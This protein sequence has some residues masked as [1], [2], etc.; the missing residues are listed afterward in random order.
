MRGFH[1][2]GPA[3]RCSLAPLNLSPLNTHLGGP[4]P[5]PLV[6]PSSPSATHGTDTTDPLSGPYQYL[7]PQLSRSIPASK[8]RTLG[9][10]SPTIYTRPHIDTS[11]GST[12]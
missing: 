1:T 12:E 6:Q 9:P 10:S 11:D 7:P 2:N 8:G 4:T 5:L 3:E